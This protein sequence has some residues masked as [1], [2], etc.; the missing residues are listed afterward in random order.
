MEMDFIGSESLRFF[1]SKGVPGFFLKLDFGF[2]DIG[3]LKL[4]VLVLHGDWI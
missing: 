3:S 2:V 1:I 4:D